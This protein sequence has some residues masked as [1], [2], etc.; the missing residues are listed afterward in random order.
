VPVPVTMPGMSCRGTRVPISLKLPGAVSGA[1]RETMVELKRLPAI[2]WLY[3]SDLP[4][5][6]TTPSRT[7]R[8]PA[9][10]P[11]CDDARPSRI[12]RAAAAAPRRLVARIAV[13]VDELATDAAESDTFVST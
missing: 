10:T 11:S 8:L 5:P 3:S 9:G 12:C 4:P 6:E 2:S 1:D 13:E 7:L